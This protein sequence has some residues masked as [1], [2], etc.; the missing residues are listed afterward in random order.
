MNASRSLGEKPVVAAT[1]PS[2]P[3]PSR[4]PSPPGYE[5]TSSTFGK[6]VRVVTSNSVSTPCF[7]SGLKKNSGPLPPMMPSTPISPP[8]K[9][10][11][12]G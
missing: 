6:A 11:V 7:R 5:N 2:V 12:L 3:S 10:P 8:L 1:R 9:P 4:G